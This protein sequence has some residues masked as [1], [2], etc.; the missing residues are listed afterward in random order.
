ML[1][2]FFCLF[3]SLSSHSRFFHSYGDVTAANFDLCSAPIA[4]ENWG[5]FS[6]PH[7]RWHGASVY[8]GHHLRG[9][10]TLSPIAERLSV[11][12]SLPVLRL[13]SVATGDR[14]RSFNVE[15]KLY[16][17]YSYGWR[18]QPYSYYGL[19][20]IRVLEF[21]HSETWQ[22]FINDRWNGDN[23]ISCSCHNKV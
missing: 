13:R 5:F 16:T 3:W 8:N 17:Y 2:W 19:K 4:I 7:L 22:L 23:C 18:S 21:P 12:L 20:S 11:K 9:P 10:V 15:R 14:S 1:I 6:V